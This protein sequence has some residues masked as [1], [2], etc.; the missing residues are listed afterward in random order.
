MPR[1]LNDHR[2]SN[3]E[4]GLVSS[5]VNDDLIL[6]QSVGPATLAA[7]VRAQLAEPS[8][9]KRSGDVH[10]TRTGARAGRRQTRAAGRYTAHAALAY[11]ALI[12]RALAATGLASRERAEVA[13]EEVL[14]GII[15]RITPEEAHHLVSQLPSSLRERLAG[16]AH[17]P[18]LR[19]TSAQLEEAV[20]RRLRLGPGAGAAVVRSVW[21]ALA[22][23]V[24]AGELEDVRSQLPADMKDL[25][26]SPS[27]EQLPH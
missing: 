2:E 21:A 22:A 17:G 27:T 19:V 9:L 3:T 20:E 11:D 10:P 26:T 6:E 12:E 13:I 23:T 25:F 5:V 14:S 16:A 18:D 8:R 4:H 24:S 15:R 1:G 7:I